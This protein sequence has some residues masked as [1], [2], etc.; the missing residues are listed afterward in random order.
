MKLI[1]IAASVLT[2]ILLGTSVSAQ[3]GEQ[4]FKAKCSACHSVGKGKLVG[5]DLKD[6]HTRYDAAWLTK[7]I[8]SSQTL[9][10]EGD[11][12]AT[13]LFN[14][15]N[16]MVMPDQDV[17]DEEVK[18]VLAYIASAGNVSSNTEWESPVEVLASKEAIGNGSLVT[19]FGFSTYMVLFLL[20]LGAIFVWITIMVRKSIRAIPRQG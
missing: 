15:N 2:V 18:Q 5:P 4:I 9:V 20:G 8:Q 17:T 10:K 19:Y 1:Q 14:E 13:K 11:E 7:W 3:D 6:V 12:Q 16:Q